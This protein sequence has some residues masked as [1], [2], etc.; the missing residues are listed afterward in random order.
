MTTK[1][2]VEGCFRD[3]GR[4]RKTWGNMSTEVAGAFITRMPI[5]LLKKGMLPMADEIYFKQYK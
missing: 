2:A 3:I 4:E 1:Q 5:S